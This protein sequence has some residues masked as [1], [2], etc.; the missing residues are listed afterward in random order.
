MSSE[1]YHA[2]RMPSDPPWRRGAY[3]A[4]CIALLAAFGI[5][6]HAPR[7]RAD[8]SLDD[9]D[10]IAGNPG[11]RSTAAALAAFGQPFP[12]QIPEKRLYRPVT[13][14]SYAIDFARWGDDARGYH[15]INTAL[16]VA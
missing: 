7:D 3:S 1:R 15:E 2:R 6:V 16:Y 11:I 5:A 8:F 9:Y 12:P 13:N 4:A 14:L 10:Y